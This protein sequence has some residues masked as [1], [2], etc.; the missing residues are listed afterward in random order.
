MAY[1]SVWWYPNY[2]EYGS[3]VKDKQTWLKVGVSH[4]LQ[5]IVLTSKWSWQSQW[6]WRNIFLGV[7][8]EQMC[9]ICMVHVAQP[10][11]SDHNKPT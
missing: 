11:A 5:N 2:T 8:L 9:I 3:G 7:R 1:R 4:T 10:P 6:I